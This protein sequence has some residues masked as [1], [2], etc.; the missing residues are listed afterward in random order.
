MPS[1]WGAGAQNLC[2]L[3]LYTLHSTALALFLPSYG[4]PTLKFQLQDY[5]MNMQKHTISVLSGDIFYNKKPNLSSSAAMRFKQ[6]KRMTEGTGINFW[7]RWRNGICINL[8]GK[9]LGK[10]RYRYPPDQI[11]CCNSDQSKRNNNMQI[12]AAIVRCWFGYR[13]EYDSFFVKHK[14]QH[15]IT[16]FRYMQTFLSLYYYWL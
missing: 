7:F 8:G 2:M 5:K 12:S 3:T 6:L 16:L 10:N 15:K 4:T 14:M 13:G 9:V 1:I 11:H